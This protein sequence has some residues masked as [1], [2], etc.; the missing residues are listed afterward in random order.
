MNC[1]DRVVEEVLQ[2]TG[3]ETGG[4]AHTRWATCGAKV[5]HN[6][7]PH[8]DQSNRFHLVHNGIITNYTELKSKYLQGVKF[9]S[10][11]DTEV[12]VQLISKLVSEGKTV[13]E[14]LVEF[15]SVAGK[16]SQWGLLVAD[17]DQPD[18]I[19]TST[20]GS[21]MLIGFAKQEDQIFV[22]SEKIAFQAYADEY[23]PTEDGE[24]LELD[25]ENVVALKKQFKDRL[26]KLENPPPLKCPPQPFKSFYSF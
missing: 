12:I 8:Y 23:F 24:I 4:I 7:H 5:T 19:Y 6:A 1:I 11:T 15:S 21:P 13:K 22:V 2:D 25:V 9:S 14:A 3:A 16:E 10:E 17:R 26:I 18:K 20:F